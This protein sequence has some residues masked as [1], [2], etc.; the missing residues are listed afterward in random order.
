MHLERAAAGGSAWAR[1]QLAEPPCPAPVAHLK[2]W[3]YEL[4]GRSGAGMTG[5]APLSY[6]ELAA[7]AHV[8]GRHVTP[9][10]VLGL[11]ALDRVIRHPPDAETMAGDAED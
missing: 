2:D 11:M 4:V 1:S 5:L 3:A 7:W 9:L 10:E 8:T 6:Q